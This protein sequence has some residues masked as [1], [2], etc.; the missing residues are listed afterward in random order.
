MATKET[1]NKSYDHK[2]NTDRGYP[3]INATLTLLVCQFC[4]PVSLSILDAF[5]KHHSFVQSCITRA[6]IFVVLLFLSRAPPDSAVLALL[7]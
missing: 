7:N 3:C 5:F 4:D 1:L 6:S 2:C